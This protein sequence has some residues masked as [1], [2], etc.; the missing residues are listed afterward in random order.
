M[1]NQTIVNIGLVSLLVLIL[2]FQIVGDINLEPTHY[3]E[4]KQI[5]AFCY[6]LSSTNKT[7]YTQIN[8]GGAKLC[9]SLWKPI[10]IDS[11]INNPELVKWS[12]NNINCT[13]IE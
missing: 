11:Y 10:P 7:C 12:C 5:K 6:T 2:T 9:Y 3:C 4:D 8:N 1:E 13:R